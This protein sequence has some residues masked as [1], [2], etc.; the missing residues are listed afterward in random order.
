MAKDRKY[1]ISI[2]PPGNADHYLPGE[3][4][5]IKVQIQEKNKRGQWTDM[6]YSARASSKTLQISSDSLK[7]D[8]ADKT[9]GQ[10]PSQG[11]FDL[12]L[13]R[14]ESFGFL[15]KNEPGKIPVTLESYQQKSSGDKFSYIAEW[16]D[17]F[18]PS[19]SNQ[20]DS[21]KEVTLPWAKLEAVTPSSPLKPGDS[22]TVKV[23]IEAELIEACDI[24]FAGSALAP[25]EQTASFP[26]GETEKT[27]AL[28]LSSENNLSEAKVKIDTFGGADLTQKQVEIDTAA[29]FKTWKLEFAGDPANQSREADG[30]FRKDT[31][32]FTV[33]VAGAADA[34]A[35]LKALVEALY[36]GETE[37][38]ATQPAVVPQGG[39]SVDV[40]FRI[41]IDPGAH[42]TADQ[43]ESEELTFR[44]ASEKDAG[45]LIP[46]THEGEKKVTVKRFALKLESTYKNANTD[47][48]DR[49]FAGDTVNFTVTLPAKVTEGFDIVLNARDPEDLDQVVMASA[50]LSVAPDQEGALTVP[51]LLPEDKAAAEDKKYTVTLHALEDA[52]AF[53]PDDDGKVEEFTVSPLPA[54]SFRAEETLEGVTPEEKGGAT[55]YR[56]PI[57][58]TYKIRIQRTEESKDILAPKVRLTGGSFMDAVEVQFEK[59]GTEAEVQTAFKSAE[60]DPAQ[61]VIE[62]VQECRVVEEQKALSVHPVEPYLFAD[63][64]NWLLP[65]WTRCAPGDQIWLRLSRNG[66]PIFTGEDAVFATVSC[67]AFAKNTAKGDER[68]YDVVFKKESDLSEYVNGEDGIRIAPED[69]LDDGKLAYEIEIEPVAVDIDGSETVTCKV[70]GTSPEIEVLKRIGFFSSETTLARTL[71][72]DTEVPVSVHLSQPARNKNSFLLKSPYFTKDFKI[73]FDAGQDRIAFKVDFDKSASLPLQMELV[74][75]KGNVA[76]AGDRDED[77]PRLLL[78]DQPPIKVCF[79]KVEPISGNFRLT[80]KRREKLPTFAL[81]E[82]ARFNIVLSEEAWED[83]SVAFLECDSFDVTDSQGGR[84]AAY[85]LVF[86]KGDRAKQVEVEFKEEGDPLEIKVRA[87]PDGESYD[88]NGEVKAVVRRLANVEEDD[89]DLGP[90]KITVRVEPLPE[91]RFGKAPENPEDPIGEW[92]DP[93][94]VPLVVGDKAK[95]YVSLGR[96]HEDDEDLVGIVKSR[97]FSPEES[98][99]KIKKDKSEPDAPIRVDI[100]TPKKRGRKRWGDNPVEIRPKDKK[101]IGFSAGVH[102]VQTLPVYEKRTIGFSF[103][104]PVAPDGPFIKEDEAVVTVRMNHPAAAGGAK[105]KLDGP[106]EILGHVPYTDPVEDPV[107]EV[108]GGKIIIPTGCDHRRVRVKFNA[109]SETEDNISLSASEGCTLGERTSVTVRVKTP[110][111]SFDQESWDARPNHRKVLAPGGVAN[112]PFALDDQCPEGGCSAKLTSDLFARHGESRTREYLLRFVEEENRDGKNQTTIDIPVD[113]D[114]DPSSGTATIT[115]SA[116]QRCEL[117]ATDFTLNLPTPP[118]IAFVEGDGLTFK[119]DSGV[120]KDGH[121][122]PAGGGDH[123]QVGEQDKEKATLS[124]A[125][126]QAPEEKVV[127][128]IQS[129]AFGANVYRVTLPAGAAAKQSVEVTFVRGRENGETTEGRSTVSLVAPDG[130]VASAHQGTITVNVKK[131]AD[132][133]TV[134]ECSGHLGEESEKALRK[135]RRRQRR[136]D[137]EEIVCNLGRLVLKLRHGDSSDNDPLK[138]GPFS[139]GTF[140]VVR[141]AKNAEKPEAAL[142]CS[143]YQAP[144]IQTTGGHPDGDPNV[145]KYFRSPHYTYVDVDL[146][147]KDRFCLNR[148]VIKEEPWVH[149]FLFA[150]DRSLQQDDIQD[151]ESRTFGQARLVDSS[152]PD[153]LE[154]PD[155][156]AEDSRQRRV[157]EGRFDW[158]PLCPAPQVHLLSSRR[159][160]RIPLYRAHQKKDAPPLPLDAPE[161]KSRRFKGMKSGYFKDVW[162]ALANRGRHAPQQ[163][164]IEAQSCGKPDPDKP[165]GPAQN[166]RAVIEVYPAD[167]YCFYL[168]NEGADSV[169][170]YLEEGKFVAPGK[171]FDPKKSFDIKGAIRPVEEIRAREEQ[172]EREGESPFGSPQTGPV[173]EVPGDYADTEQTGAQPSVE[174]AEKT[175]PSGT[176]LSQKFYTRVAR[177]DTEPYS[178]EVDPFKPPSRVLYPYDGADWRDG[179]EQRL[180]AE[181]VPV[182]QEAEKFGDWKEPDSDPADKD[183]DKAIGSGFLSKIF[184]IEI[185]LGRNGSAFNTEDHKFVRQW[186]NA[187]SSCVFVLVDIINKASEVSSPGFG[188]GFQLKLTFLRGHYVRYWGWKE[189][190]D[191]RVFWWNHNCIDMTLIGVEIELTFGFKVGA[192]GCKIEAVIFGSIGGSLTVHREFEKNEPTADKAGYVDKWTSTKTEAKLGVRVVLGR[193]QWFSLEAALKVG[194]TFRIRTSTYYGVDFEVYFD[195]LSAYIE[196][197]LICLFNFKGEKVLIKG[198]VAGWP[199]ASF[200]FGGTGKRRMVY[201]NRAI[202]QGKAR[203]EYVRTHIGKYLRKYQEVQLLMVADQKITTGQRYPLT[204]LVPGQ[205]YD[206]AEGMFLSREDWDANKQK[207]DTQ[208]AACKGR[209]HRETKRVVR[210]RRVGS[211]HATLGERLTSKNDRIEALVEQ[212]EEKLDAVDRLEKRI[213][214]L[215]ERIARV[216]EQDGGGEDRDGEITETVRRHKFEIGKDLE[217]EFLKEANRLKD[218]KAIGYR[219]MREGDLKKLGQLIEGLAYYAPMREKW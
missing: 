48:E 166:L 2:D 45:Y 24:K 204:V 15:V 163:Y 113:P 26:V 164:L 31:L 182:N 102:S 201:A 206:P 116:P 142:V 85:D 181:F 207:W 49:F 29:F 77:H 218:D 194:Y 139:D 176:P 186:L 47:R 145:V 130:W 86:S 190:S 63:E 157:T 198:N 143:R 52:Y 80:G 171:E 56:V 205:R 196:L 159:M 3:K 27:F 71:P 136:E 61:I 175:L 30:P 32:K 140:E 53:V 197:R 212:F 103:Q 138:R 57:K 179:Q 152:H 203:I 123:F 216:L 137:T 183:L 209:F 170:E 144:V 122:K 19:G 58:K 105:V 28:T 104:N 192:C 148:F 107:P 195:G 67:P 55:V 12:K 121:L 211:W 177:K 112:L 154:P 11:P 42:K 210:R 165:F 75:F 62:P 72:G 76:T 132:P 117:A 78:R 35:D 18:E 98:E 146:S 127:V 191:H 20:A 39:S 69:E 68:K 129:E 25:A 162:A 93:A 178:F 5:Q 184:D 153:L 33:Q 199:Q 16:G 147:P 214:A 36:P 97:A 189:C 187:F 59:D 155:S 13:K 110:K 119:D 149:P 94:G 217:A 200:T 54:V 88:Y 158:A 180:D 1:Q 131:P 70:E 193:P 60:A 169:M 126:S 219:D 99:F 125:P 43:P 87:A 66:V 172:L 90:A 17:G 185:H 188:W 215:Q 151:F 79:D 81:G 100:K 65:P 38:F 208:W 7:A 115:L 124:V 213:E 10:G 135:R 83:E 9:I 50:P 84:W 91:I 108:T 14:R 101:N 133:D 74:A 160:A 161:R 4:V 44:I 73:D 174:Q 120:K 21:E 111:V 134:S 95:V 64:K 51:F 106:F 23:S 173:D 150:A 114:A 109:D 40:P 128:G 202:T 92:I 41:D 46:G 34:P 156:G 168:G 22:L 6:S 96:P 89:S 141:Q 82:R 8:P 167:E 37:P 118:E